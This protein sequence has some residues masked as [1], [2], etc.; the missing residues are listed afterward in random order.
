MQSAVPDPA[1]LRLFADDLR[2][3]H[4]RSVLL[5]WYGRFRSGYGDL[6]ALMRAVLWHALLKSCGDSLTVQPDAGIRHPE[7]FIIGSGI[8]VGN[9]ALLQGRFDG[10]CEIGDHTWIGPHSFLDARDLVLG[11]YVGWGPGAKILGS[12]HTGV[13]IDVPII[14]TE[15]QIQPV[16]VGDWADI[17]TGAVILPG[18]TIGK[19]AIVGAGAVVTRDVPPF[20]VVAGVPAKI[21]EWREMPS[22]HDGL[23]PQRSRD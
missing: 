16:R 17:G 1:F 13:P 5:D 2:S 4:D 23:S 3:K 11:S 8:F 21:I 12:E 19:G 10:R 7:T 18:I 14:Q 6:D 9:Q 22:D 20:A 15:L